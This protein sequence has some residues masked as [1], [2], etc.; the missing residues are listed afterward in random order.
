MEAPSE[1]SVLPLS[2]FGAISFSGC[3]ATL[4]GVTGPISAWPDD[5]LT[6]ETSKA[7]TKAAP[8]KLGSTG[9]TFSVTWEHQ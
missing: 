1:N 4:Q 2:D 5:E 6:M 8:S 9:E 3:E 7:V